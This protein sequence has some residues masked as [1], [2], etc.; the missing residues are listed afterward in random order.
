MAFSLSNFKVAKQNVP[1]AGPATREKFRSLDWPAYI[2]LG[3]GT[4]LLCLG[5]LWANNPYPW[6]NAHVLAPLLVGLIILLALTVYACKFKTDGLFNHALFTNRNFPIS[7][8]A[9]AAEGG[10]Y[11]VAAVF[12]PCSLSVLPN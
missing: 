12:F 2:L 5:L 1:G 10:I 6:S 11:M 4:V 8:M 3:S 7:L 9:L